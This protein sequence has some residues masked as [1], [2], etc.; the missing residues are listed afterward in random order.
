[1]HVFVCVYLF[2]FGQLFVLLSSAFLFA[3]MPCRVSLSLLFFFSSSLPPFLPHS[4][5]QTSLEHSPKL[6][7]FQPIL[8]FTYMYTYLHMYI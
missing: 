2:A 8:I 5:V 6:N 3:F 7:H 4:F 1:M